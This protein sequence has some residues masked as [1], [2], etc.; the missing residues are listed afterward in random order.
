MFASVKTLLVQY[1]HYSG[2]LFKDAHGK[3]FY[4]IKLIMHQPSYLC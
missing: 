4:K 3:A 1:V 2:I